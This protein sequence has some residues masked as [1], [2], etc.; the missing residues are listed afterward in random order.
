M[1][2]MSLRCHKIGHDLRPHMVLQNR[3]F[4]GTPPAVPAL[5]PP[6]RP[7]PQMLQ[8]PLPSPVCFTVTPHR[9]FLDGI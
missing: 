7:R 6:S 8:L 2:W 4:A 3:P 5:P 9:S 1:D